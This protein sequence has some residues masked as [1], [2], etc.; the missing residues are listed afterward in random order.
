MLLY[1]FE[2]IKE[3]NFVKD[4]NRF[5]SRAI[6]DLGIEI[7]TKSFENE[8]NIFVLSNSLVIY[9]YIKKR[10]FFAENLFILRS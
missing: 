6:N 9:L 3:T 2:I 4:A 5:T 1:I 7:V 10:K 8:E